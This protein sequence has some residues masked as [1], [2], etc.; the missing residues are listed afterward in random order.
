[1][2]RKLCARVVRP[3]GLE[4]H[5]EVP[6][7]HG[8]GGRPAGHDRQARGG[9]RLLGQNGDRIAADVVAARIVLVVPFLVELVEFVVRVHH[10]VQVIV[11]GG[12][13]VWNGPRERGGRLVD[14]RALRPASKPNDLPVQRLQVRV[15]ALSAKA[16]PAF[17]PPVPLQSPA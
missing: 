10:K 12:E 4:G 11:A 5:L 13:V 1:M 9:L 2:I 3:D 17:F 7:R 14:L 8:C 15:P 6:F 16:L